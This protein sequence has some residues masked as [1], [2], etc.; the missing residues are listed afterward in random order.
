MDGI[1]LRVLFLKLIIQTFSFK[2]SHQNRFPK[3]PTRLVR[4]WNPYD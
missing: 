2:A 3:E 4:F 1:G